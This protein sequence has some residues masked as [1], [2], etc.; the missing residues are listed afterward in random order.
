MIGRKP[1]HRGANANA[2]EAELGD[3]RVDNSHRTEFVE[4]SFRD[5]VRAV[6][7]RDFLAH[8]EDAVVALKLFAQRLRE[9]VAIGEDCHVSSWCPRGRLS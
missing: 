1:N 5:F 4:Q 8:E 2:G 6:V 3:R 9:R 7:L